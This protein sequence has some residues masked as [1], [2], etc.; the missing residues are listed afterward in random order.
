MRLWRHPGKA[1]PTIPVSAERQNQDLFL[2][3]NLRGREFAFPE[4]TNPRTEFLL[5]I[6]ES[7]LVRLRRGPRPD[8][9]LSRLVSRRRGGLDLHLYLKALNYNILIQC[10]CRT[11]RTLHHLDHPSNPSLWPCDLP[12]RQAIQYKL[13]SL[14]ILLGV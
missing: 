8:R 4:T 2:G 9:R 5:P 13:L 12:N 3:M 7:L 6:G 1:L 14:R 10:P 11:R